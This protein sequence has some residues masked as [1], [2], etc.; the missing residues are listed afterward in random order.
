MHVAVLISGQIVTNEENMF[1]I[2]HNGDTIPK[3]INIQLDNKYHWLMN[4]DTK[5]NLLL[6]VPNE[7]KR[8]L[9][10]THENTVSQ[11]VTNQEN[12]LTYINTGKLPPFFANTKKTPL[13][14]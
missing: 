11:I 6:G 7:W 1:Q 8:L 9:A 13:V 3:V 10:T 5:N 12:I 2:V 4:E 14:S